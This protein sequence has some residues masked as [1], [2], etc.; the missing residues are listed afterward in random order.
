MVR[1]TTGPG[2]TSSESPVWAFL[3][4]MF[5]APQARAGFRRGVRSKVAV[6]RPV[7]RANLPLLR[8]SRAAGQR[9]QPAGARGVEASHGKEAMAPERRPGRPRGMRGLPLIEPP[10]LLG[11]LVG[12]R[13]V[14][15]G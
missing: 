8:G 1:Q 2:S 6:H 15:F 14:L 4:A 9:R 5:R 13:A 3:P 12:G 11:P 10:G 7:P